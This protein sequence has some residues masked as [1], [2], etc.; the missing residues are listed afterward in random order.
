LAHSTDRGQLTALGQNR[1]S[2]RKIG[3]RDQNRE[4]F[5]RSSTHAVEAL[6][7]ELQLM[8][9]YT[10]R[11]SG[12]M[13][14]R[15]SGIYLVERSR[16]SV[17]PVDA[18]HRSYIY[19]CMHNIQIF[20]HNGCDLGSKC[21]DRSWTCYIKDFRAKAR[22]KPTVDTVDVVQVFMEPMTRGAEIL[23]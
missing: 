3:S 20:L 4:F 13:S 12:F 19:A 10:T 7:V 14:H 2:L 22:A 11:P 5:W 21:F 17:R 6:P 9:M 8:C 16:C 1:S 15:K 18:I 23:A